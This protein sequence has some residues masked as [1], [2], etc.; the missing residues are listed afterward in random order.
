MI[1]AKFYDDEEFAYKLSECI[2]EGAVDLYFTGE[3]GGQWG[4]RVTPNKVEE[5][6]TMWVTEAEH[7]Q[8]RALKELKEGYYIRFYD[9]ENTFGLI[10][11]PQSVDPKEIEK[12][13]DEY[14]KSDDAYTYYDF[15]EYLEEKGI[16]FIE[17]PQPN[18]VK[19]VNIYF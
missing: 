16:P 7:R 8:F 6:H 19:A 15:I 10:Q 14:K 2:I 13:L 9:S 12:I 1:Y 5:I 11:V 17:I 4:Y 3:D 18:Q